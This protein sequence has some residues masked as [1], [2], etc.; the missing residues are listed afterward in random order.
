MRML[1]FF[2]QI[3]NL[4]SHGDGKVNRIFINKIRKIPFETEGYKLGKK[5]VLTD[6]DISDFNFI[7]ITALGRFDNA[8][9]KS[10]PEIIAERE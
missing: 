6:E 7:L 5:I 2:K 3:R 9:V 1:D 8:F 4:Y 10:Y